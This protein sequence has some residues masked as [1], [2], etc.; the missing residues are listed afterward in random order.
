MAE[1]KK[2]KKIMEKKIDMAQHEYRFNMLGLSERVK[3][4]IKRFL[5]LLVPVILII[6][7]ILKTQK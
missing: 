4:I 3:R 5:I 6:Y 1:K 7:W 2:E